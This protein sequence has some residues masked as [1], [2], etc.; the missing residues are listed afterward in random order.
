MPAQRYTVQVNNSSAYPIP[1]QVIN[2]VWDGVPSTQGSFPSLDN[3]NYLNTEIEEIGTTVIASDTNF[4]TSRQDNVFT[5]VRVNG[6]LTINSGFTVT[7]A[8]RKL[9]LAVLVTGNCTINGTLSMSSRGANHQGYNNAGDDSLTKGGDG[10]GFYGTY[11]GRNI[12]IYQG[13]LNTVSFSGT[14]VTVGGLTSNISLGDSGGAG[15]SSASGT[16]GSAGSIGT[17]GGGGSGGITSSTGNRFGNG[18]AGTTFSGGSGGGGRYGDG[19]NLTNP[20]VL[21]GKPNG[22]KG[23]LGFSGI[24]TVAGGGAGNPGGLGA[25]GTNTVGNDGTQQGGSG[26]GAPL[27][28]I[29]QG[30]LTIGATGKILSGGVQGGLG[31]SNIANNGGGSGGGSITLIAN[32]YTLSTGYVISAAGGSGRFGSGAGGAGSVSFYRFPV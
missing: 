31:T 1:S 3:L 32:G 14:T 17:C 23:G 20:I 8:A 2:E 4:G 28:L 18:A 27:I 26:S 24:N 19:S 29:V 9:G 21:D 11:P 16:A 5:L 12:R 30:T 6:N 25:N 22:G 13:S 7:T 15:A 10:S